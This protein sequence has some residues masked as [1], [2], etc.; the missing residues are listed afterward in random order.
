MI[1]TLRH[2]CLRRWAESGMNPYKLMRR[3]GHAD[4]ETTMRYIHMA[5]PQGTE[6]VR[7][8]HNFPHKADFTILKGGNR[9][10]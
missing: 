4:L 2:T 10:D 8:P 9:I 3:A 6:E 7:S 5:G 1:Y